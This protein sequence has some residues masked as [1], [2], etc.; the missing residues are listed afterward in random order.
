MKITLNS[1]HIYTVEDGNNIY[2]PPSVSEILQDLG[3]IDSRWFTERSRVRGTYV[4]KACE[5]YD[6]NDL[7]LASVHSE[8]EPYVN[9]YIEFCNAHKPVYEL[10]EHKVYNSVSFYCGTLDRYGQLNGKK[11]IIDLKTGT[12][13]I[14]H[15]YQLAAYAYALGQYDISLYTLHLNNRG[16]YSLIEHDIKDGLKTWLACCQVYNS[17]A[18][19]T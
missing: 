16:G 15:K 3:Y 8:I 17:K 1:D 6:N 13:S 14:S 4:H 2:H 7:D 18:M 11:S 5:L 10:I 12:S 19:Q 9:A